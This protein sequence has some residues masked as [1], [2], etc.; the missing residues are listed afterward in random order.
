M[1]SRKYYRFGAAFRRLRTA[2]GVTQIAIAAASGLTDARM[3]KLERGRIVGPCHDAVLRIARALQLSEIETLSL[4]E[5]AAHDR[6]MRVFVRNFPKTYQQEL[7]AAALDVARL[8]SQEDCLE[9]AK[10]MRLLA[11][12]RQGVNAFKREVEEAAMT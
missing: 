2:R 7:I 3:N 6:C 8:N 12:G 1:E 10:A 11:G 5:T 4:H 9:L